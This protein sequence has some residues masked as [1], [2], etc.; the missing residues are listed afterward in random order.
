MEFPELPLAFGAYVRTRRTP[1]YT[2]A[3]AAMPADTGRSAPAALALCAPIADTA[4]RR[5][6]AI[7]LAQPRARTLPPLTLL[8][9]P[10]AGPTPHPATAR[11][12]IL[13]VEDDPH[14]ASMIRAAL[15][16]ESESGW[17]VEVAADGIR[18]LELA[19]RIPPQCVLLD[20]SLPGLD[21]GEVYRRLCAEPTTAQTHV[22]FLTGATSLE[23]FQRGIEGGV[24]LRKPFDVRELAGIVRALLAAT[25]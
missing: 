16:L 18:A 21:G 14:T 3:R 11:Q 1:P 9:H 17:H 2:G 15:E 25:P 20:V 4:R 6:L 24:L 23:L 7:P 5:P 19:R 22:L 12:H 13:I 10:E 8:E